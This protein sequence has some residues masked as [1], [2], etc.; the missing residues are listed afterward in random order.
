MWQTSCTH[1]VWCIPL[2]SKCALS[3]W[4]PSLCSC[5][6]SLGTSSFPLTLRA[7]WWKSHN[8]DTWTC[9]HSWL[10]QS[11][12]MKTIALVWGLTHQL[13][14]RR[15]MLDASSWWCEMCLSEWS[16]LFSHTANQILRMFETHSS[17]TKPHK[18]CQANAF[19]F[20]WHSCETLNFWNLSW[21][22]ACLF[23]TQS[24]VASTCTM[25]S[26]TVCLVFIPISWCWT[27]GCRRWKVR[28]NLWCGGRTK[29]LQ[30]LGKREAR[31]LGE[32]PLT[33][34]FL[35]CAPPNTCSCQTTDVW[36]SQLCLGDQN[37]NL[38]LRRWCKFLFVQGPSQ[39]VFET[40][41]TAAHQA[42]EHWHQMHS[43]AKVCLQGWNSKTQFQEGSTTSVLVLVILC[44][45]WW[46]HH[47]SSTCTQ[48]LDHHGL[49]SH[50]S[51]TWTY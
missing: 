48:Q 38:I 3:Q 26:A 47:L 8:L 42:K 39:C 25:L 29:K 41:C 1:D 10:V 51:M 20:F 7:M 44:Q 36:C 50:H 45:C 15:T 35:N 11:Q 33:T 32:L 16:E 17:I 23:V 34:N 31:W 37:F 21:I 13:F 46:H 28:E 19:P 14:W 49:A 22:R 9:L 40:R 30:F 6:L 27:K 12:E 4:K 24:T 43:F 5:V 18:T 2:T